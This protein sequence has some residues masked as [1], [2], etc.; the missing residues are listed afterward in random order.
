[1]KHVL[2]ETNWVVGYAA[3]AHHQHPD[4]K[5]LL[6]RAHAGELQIH[7]PS[8]CLTEARFTIPRKFQPRTEA[9]AIRKFLVWAKR[10]GSVSPEEDAIVR[11]AVDMFESRVRGELG[12]LGALIDAIRRDPAIEVFS[13]DDEMLARAASIGG[14]EL[15]LQPFD[16]A[17]LAAVL[18]KSERLHAGGSFELCFCETDGDLQPWDR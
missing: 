4:A 3:P 6:A 10:E 8:V 17:I 2:V 13:L 16:Q 5:A 11:R 14:S 12:E 9:D 18:V 1:M 15:E 7:L